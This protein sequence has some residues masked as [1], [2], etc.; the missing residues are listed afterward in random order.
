MN[1]LVLSDIQDW[2]RWQGGAGNADLVISCGDIADKII[3]EAARAYRCNKIFA[4]KGNHDYSGAFTGP[5]I[6]L[7]LHV[8]EYQGVR[9]GGFNGSWKYKP[10]GNFL[11]EQLE[12]T[13]LLRSFPP[14]DIFVSHNSPRLV[15]DKDDEVHYG[16]NAFNHYVEINKPKMLLHGHQHKQQETKMGNSRIIATY[17]HRTVYI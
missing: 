1:I 15:H 14:V 12:V 13:E 16:F 2:V 7:H 11:Y 17:G 9:F 10:K 8:E 6:D 4:V 5:I 3:L